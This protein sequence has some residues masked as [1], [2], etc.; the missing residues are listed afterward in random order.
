MLGGEMMTATRQPWR[1]WHYSVIAGRDDGVVWPR[2][3][4][5]DPALPM[6]DGIT[7]KSAKWPTC[8]VNEGTR[9]THIGGRSLR[10]FVVIPTEMFVS[11]FLPEQPLA[12]QLH[13]LVP[14]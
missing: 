1:W 10:D 4:G 3:T 9:C 2:L 14:P 5:C 6:C 11:G 13:P 12:S 8:A 7:S